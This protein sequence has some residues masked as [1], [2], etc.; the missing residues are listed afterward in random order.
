[1]LDLID[2]LKSSSEVIKEPHISAL[3]LCSLPEGYNNLIV[4]V[5]ARPENE[6][7]TKF[8]R[9]K[10]LDEYNLRKGSSHSSHDNNSRIY[11]T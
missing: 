7:N 2:K 4:A 10:L 3:M 1:M 5:E 6:L 11:K 8:I 9:N